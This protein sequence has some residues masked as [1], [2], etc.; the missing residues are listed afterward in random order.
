MPL[1]TDRSSRGI[2]FI[3]F[4]FFTVSRLNIVDAN[5][6]IVGDGLPFHVAAN[7]DQHGNTSDHV[8]EGEHDY[9]PDQPIERYTNYL[10][11][12]GNERIDRKEPLLY[13]G[14]KDCW[15]G[16]RNLCGGKE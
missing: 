4:I 9:E 15:K 3:L 14:L 12:F 6:L 5:I 1:R 11:S 2:L 7:G 13:K 16:K 8:K 10:F